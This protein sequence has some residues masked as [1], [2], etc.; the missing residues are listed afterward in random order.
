MKQRI[1]KLS[2]LTLSLALPFMC[3]KSGALTDK[4]I[5]ST[6]SKAQVVSYIETQAKLNPDTNWSVDDF[7][8]VVGE[9]ESYTPAEVKSYQPG[10]KTP[11]PGEQAKKLPG[12]PVIP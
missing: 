5:S 12:V 9:K 3:S 7:F 11:A 1:I 4:N 2:L 6:I 10:K 8:T